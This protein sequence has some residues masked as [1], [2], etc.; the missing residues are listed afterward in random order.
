MAAP[1]APTLAAAVEAARSAARLTLG[2]AA[3]TATLDV[4][5]VSPSGATAYVRGWQGGVVSS[6][7][8]L[9]VR[10]YEL[11]QGLEV[12]YYARAYSAA[13]E[14]SA[15]TG[16]IVATLPVDASGTDWLVDLAR[17]TNSTPVL[18]ERLADLS[19]E[20]PHGVHRVLTRRDPVVTSDIAWTPSSELVFVTATPDEQERALATLGN[21]VPLLLKTPP[22]HGVGNVYFSIESFTQGRP[23]RLAQH[24]DRRFTVR[25]VQV[26]RPDPALFVP[27]PPVTYAAVKATFAT[28][29]QLKAQR[30]TYDDLA[31]SYTSAAPNPI[32]PWP[33]QDV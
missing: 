17:P 13:S 21:G 8:T 16:P 4:W 22:A 15:T 2:V 11:P 29:A 18:V 1:A 12:R 32:A 33:P 7:T 25:A 19:Y 14:A 24:S 27:A 31:Y 6:P 5:R 10:D 3:G 26:V 30:A 9:V 23:S 20:I 28:Y